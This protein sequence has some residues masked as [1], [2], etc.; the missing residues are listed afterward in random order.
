MAC[1]E[2]WSRRGVAH[3]SLYFLSNL[4][5]PTAELGE[6]AKTDTCRTCTPPVHEPFLAATQVVDVSDNQLTNNHSLKA[7]LRLPFA[8]TPGNQ[9]GTS[10]SPNPDKRRFEAIP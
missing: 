3:C 2:I 5:R 8:K 6:S 7:R 1:W 4:R 10:A 9:I